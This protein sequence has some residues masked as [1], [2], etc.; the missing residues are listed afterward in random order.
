MK[1]KKGEKCIS[2]NGVVGDIVEDFQGGLYLIT[3]V[4]DIYGEISKNYRAIDLQ[5]WNTNVY[6]YDRYLVANYG[7]INKEMLK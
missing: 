4:E 2:V 3:K 6:I 1:V 7:K 5:G